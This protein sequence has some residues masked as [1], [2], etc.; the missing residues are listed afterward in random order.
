VV[1]DLHDGAQQRL[2]HTIITL[3]PAHQALHPNQ[4]PG[5]ELAR[6]GR[7]SRIDACAGRLFATQ[8][9]V[10]AGEDESQIVVREPAHA[11]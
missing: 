10:D 8:H 6:S 4:E 3:K 9:E 11:V 5:S 1:R 7:R 2:V